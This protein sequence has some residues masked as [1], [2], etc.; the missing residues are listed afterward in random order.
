MDSTIFH[1]DL[2]AFFASVEQLDF[3]ELR[4]KPVIIGGDSQRGVVATASYEARRYGVRSAMAMV[5]AKKKC[6]E[7][8][9]ISGRF[10]RYAELSRQV[11]R[12]IADMATQVEQ[13]S[14]DEAYLDLSDLMQSASDTDCG[15][16]IKTRVYEGT[17]LTLSVGISYN[18][19]LAKLAS[20]WD[21]PNGLMRIDPTMVPD[22]LL[23]LPISKIHGLGQKSVQKLNRIGI[24]TVDDLYGYS[25]E[26]LEELI[27][28]Y[29]GVVYH[30]IRG[31]DHRPLEL[32]YERKSYGKEITFDEDT[33][34]KR[35]LKEEIHP[36]CLSISNY[37]QKENL[38]AKRL[39]LK[40]KTNQHESHTRSKTVYIP[41]QSTAE[42]QQ[43]AHVM[44]DELT[45]N[46]PLRL[47]GLTASA[48][49]PMESKQF[50]V[51]E[52]LME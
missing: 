12:I 10:E 7:G 35:F 34:D 48:F 31:I 19:F 13:V 24:F 36:F 8:I 50:S 9:I 47:V 11:F 3:P 17:G 44:I 20:D 4:G 40:Y 1:V 32:E 30:L 42:I 52:A 16:L 51:F 25:A 29:G 2:D 28:K 43:L 37:L 18:K 5:T 46:E 41:L 45:L 23:P 39:T 22:I 26:L 6:P 21:K 33:C 49:E 38:L 14:I 27:G 15:R